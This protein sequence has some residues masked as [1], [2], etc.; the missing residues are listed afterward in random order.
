MRIL[1]PLDGSPR[2][3]HAMTKGLELLKGAKLDVTL[4]AVSQGGFHK[5]GSDRVDEF[6]ADEEDEVFPTLE[7]CERM[8]AKAEKMVK[9]KV[10]KK[11]VAG[12]VH[13]LI[14]EETA[15]HD[16]VLMHSLDASGLLEKIRLSGTERIARKAKCSV[17][18]VDAPR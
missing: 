6:V 12:K 4:F 11:V 14:L 18:L 17:F 10:T 9:G 2:S 8:L 7:S 3:F 1:V 16:V 13:Q 15:H 5:A